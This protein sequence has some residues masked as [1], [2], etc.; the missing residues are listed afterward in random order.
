MS[1]EK[2]LKEG[3]TAIGVIVK[4]DW[5]GLIREMPVKWDMFKN[6]VSQINHRKNNVMM[7]ISLEEHNGMYTQFICTEVGENSGVPKGMK[8][9]NIPSHHY[10]HQVHEGSL[11][12]IAETFGRMYRY[13]K[14]N[15]IKLGNMKLD[16]GY[17]IEGEEKV[18]DLY[19]Q[20]ID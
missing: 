4:Q 2:L 11:V 14:A 18:H 17:T 5:E 6:R 13:G 16:V 7:D 12:G 8:V 19:I 15:G 10:L 1:M 20:I 3:F 9:R